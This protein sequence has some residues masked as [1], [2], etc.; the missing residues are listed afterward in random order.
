VRVSPL[1]PPL[2]LPLSARRRRSHA[3]ISLTLAQPSSL[4]FLLVC[5]SGGSPVSCPVFSPSFLP[6]FASFAFLL[7]SPY[8]G[9]PRL[10]FPRR[11]GARLSAFLIKWRQQNKERTENGYLISSPSCS[12]PA[13]YL[14]A[15]PR[16]P[17]DTHLHTTL[18]AQDQGYS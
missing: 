9:Y 11:E 8:S 2:S 13:P 18:S 5:E 10:S 16:L 14:S 3:L 1:L 4:S 17:I 15:L 6:S 7:F 12:L